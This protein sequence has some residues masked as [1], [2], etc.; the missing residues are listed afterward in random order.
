MNKYSSELDR[1]SNYQTVDYYNSNR[2]WLQLMRL[3]AYSSLFRWHFGFKTN[4]APMRPGL[5]V[6]YACDAAEKVGAKLEFLG[7]EMD[8]TTW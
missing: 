5:E 4:F 1:H 7:P 3:G 2:R 8:Q 6:K